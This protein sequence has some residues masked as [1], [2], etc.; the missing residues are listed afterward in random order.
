MKHNLLV[1]LRFNNFRKIA[2]LL[3]LCQ[4]SA[5]LVNP[6][7]S[8]FL[9]QSIHASNSQIGFYVILNSL[10]A[11][12]INFWIANISDKLGER[13]VFIGLAIVSAIIG[14]MIYAHEKSYMVILLVSI[15]IIG[16]STTLTSQI[17]AY[18][19]EL[20]C[21]DYES[22]DYMVS[23]LRIVVSLAWVGSPIIGAYINNKYN[24]NG[25]FLC[26]S[27]VYFFALI[28]LLWCFGLKRDGNVKVEQEKKQSGEIYGK[29]AIVSY[30]LVFSFLQSINTVLNTVIPLY[31][32]ETLNNSNVFV[33]YIASFSAIVEI[34]ITI[35]LV[36]LSLKVNIK[37]LIHLGM[38]GGLT[39]LIFLIFIKNIYLIIAIHI[40]KAIFVSSYMALGITFFQ[41]MISKRYGFSTVLY[42]NTTRMGN[43]FGGFITSITG[44]N[45]IR[46]FLILIIL[47]ILSQVI[48][49]LTN[50][51]AS[52]TSKII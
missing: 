24:Y 2:L 44:K 20:F 8:L 41:N 1:A 35:Y 12:F 25:L 40:F 21:Y 50:L 52:K 48:Y 7:I 26:C 19:K 46:I 42:T 39:F 22:N 33:G 31:V 9:S 36:K 11:M 5:G 10:F 15:S 17:F 18:A 27:I 45:Y 4:L 34:P 47:C 28:T 3:L 29:S 16:I 30:F 38:M 49:S 43:I 6:F 23:L 14:Y 37:K 32:T 13:K 51:F